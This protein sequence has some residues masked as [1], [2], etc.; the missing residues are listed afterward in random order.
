LGVTDPEK[1]P[2]VD[3]VLVPIGQE[4]YSTSFVL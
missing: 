2:N 1:W 4:T 3:W